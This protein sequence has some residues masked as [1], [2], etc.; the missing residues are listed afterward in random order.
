MKKRKKKN[1]NNMKFDLYNTYFV[2]FT[3]EN[4]NNILILFFHKS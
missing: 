3:K 4:I 1:I 2:F